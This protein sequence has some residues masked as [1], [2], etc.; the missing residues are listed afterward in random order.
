M[1]INAFQQGEQFFNQSRQADDAN[2]AAA[3]A[4]TKAT[5]VEKGIN[6]LGAKF[7]E[8][9]LAPAEF[10]AVT[11]ATG[12]A[13]QRKINQRDT[14]EDRVIADKER[15][16]VDKL[17]MTDKAVSFF[18]AGIANNEK[19]EDIITRVGPALMQMGVSEEELGNLPQYLTDNPQAIPEM[20]AA[21]DADKKK[22]M[23]PRRQIGLPVEMTLP[24]G[25]TGV[26]TS[27][28][29]GT[30]EWDQGVS[31]TKNDLG[32]GR[33]DN[34]VTSTEISARNSNLG[35]SKEDRA[36]WNDTK[37]ELKN[38]GEKRAFNEL[39]VGAATTVT[40]DIN[41]IMDSFDSATFGG[42][43]MT[44]ALARAAA[45]NVPGTD[46]FEINELINSVKSNVGIDSL[47]GIKKAGSGLGQV[48]QSQLTTLQS[49]LGNLNLTRDPVNLKRDLNDINDRYQNI[50]ALTQDSIGVLDKR[51]NVL[52]K[53]RLDLEEKLYPTNSADED[54]SIDELLNQYAP[55]E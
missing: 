10:A 11:N 37:T 23:G 1:A 3:D 27:Y 25:T 7:G 24:N 48:P 33:L 50:I 39:T 6:A 38:T 22:A 41:T 36:L 8:E 55:E 20:R 51:E 34:S 40:R 45:K 42:T 35:F 53:R 13:A 12:A 2:V 30:T 44:E 19:M 28:S 26:Q 9:A 29:D 18:E 54:L 47:L 49:L 32:R 52:L 17:A 21:L 16:D 43:S 4:H 5:R 14:E 46:A 15:E 31:L